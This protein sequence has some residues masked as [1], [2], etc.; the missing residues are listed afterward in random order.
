MDTVTVLS[1]AATVWVESNDLNPR[2]AVFYPD[3][4]KAIIARYNF[5]KYP[6]KFE[7][8]DETK[9]VSFASGKLGETVIERLAIYTYGISLETRVSTEESKRLLEEGLRW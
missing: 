1:A 6:E 2:G 8:F 9:G 5:Q 3:L 4:A 7:D